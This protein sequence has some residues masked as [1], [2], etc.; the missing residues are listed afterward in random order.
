M[1]RNAVNPL[2]RIQL[3]EGCARPGIGLEAARTTGT[4]QQNAK[5]LDV[6][7]PIAARSALRKPGRSCQS[8]SQ[9]IKDV[10]P[11]EVVIRKSRKK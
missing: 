11:S 6:K 4:P 5:P 7:V 1:R 2:E 10:Y 8:E 3:D 9:T